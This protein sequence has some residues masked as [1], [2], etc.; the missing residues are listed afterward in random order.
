MYQTNEAFTGGNDN[1]KTQTIEKKYGKSL[2]ITIHL[3]SMSP[4]NPW[5]N[6]G[7]GH[8]KTRLFTIKTSK[9]VGFGGP[10]L[11]DPPPFLGNYLMTP[12]S[13]R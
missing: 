7:F 8:L 5:K 3:H 6:K 2:Q 13:C 1:I 4:Q 11:F 10:W 12:D 9:N